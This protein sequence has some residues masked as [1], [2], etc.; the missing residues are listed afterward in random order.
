ME[1]IKVESMNT[2]YGSWVSCLMN[3]H[4]VTGVWPL[5]ANT[6]EYAKGART[7][8]RVSGGGQFFVK[9]SVIDI[10]RVINAM[11]MK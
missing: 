1:M 5:P 3:P 9:E 2:D 10:G 4:Y 7:E 8:I 6:V 11:V